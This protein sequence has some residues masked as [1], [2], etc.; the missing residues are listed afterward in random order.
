MVGTEAN[1][2][3][4]VAISSQTLVGP[5]SPWILMIAIQVI[6]GYRRCRIW[7]CSFCIEKDGNHIMW[8][9]F[10]IGWCEMKNWCKQTN[11]AM[12]LWHSFG[13]R[14]RKCF[15][16]GPWSMSDRACWNGRNRWKHKFQ[17]F[18]RA[19]CRYLDIW[20]YNES[21]VGARRCL[22]VVMT[23]VSL[24]RKLLCHPTSLER[25]K[26]PQV[27]QKYTILLLEVS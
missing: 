13:I 25:T 16:N 23:W 1:L 3:W 12:A 10:T 2:I 4:I 5:L 11:S 9:H 14:P 24:V 20:L 26:W 6:R 17:G 7:N 18:G 27:W 8:M 22:W 19:A 21:W 15:F